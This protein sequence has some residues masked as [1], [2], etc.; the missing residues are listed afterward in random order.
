[1]G[2]SYFTTVGGRWFN[3]TELCRGPWDAN[4]C[5]AGPPTGLAVRALEQMLPTM[6]LARVTVDVLRPIPMSGFRVQTEVTRPGR[7]ATWSQAELFDADQVYV[8]VG[9][10]HLRTLEQFDVRTAPVDTPQFSR[11]VPG[12]FP[13]RNTRHDLSGFVDSVEVRY[14]PSSPL[15]NGGP[16]V[17]WA[18]TVPLLDDEEPSGFQRLCPLADSG[19]GI[20]FNQPLDEVLFVNPDL[21]ISVHRPPVGEWIGSRVISHWRSDGTGL[22]DAE[23][24][25][26]TGSVGRATQTLLLNPATG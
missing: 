7:S 5:H 17:I 15:G 20:S 9:A 16:T 2:Q 13:I 21:V 22:T 6:R 19:N 12:S 3:P 8:R 10:L 23:L 14:D 18:R 26:Q 11:A 1:M 24:F 25:D 4:A